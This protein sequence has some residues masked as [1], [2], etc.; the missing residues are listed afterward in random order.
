MTNL[1]TN[2]KVSAASLMSKATDVAIQG[3]VAFATSRLLRYSI[4]SSIAI[5]LLQMDRR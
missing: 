5:R 4:I 2:E 3:A 1:K